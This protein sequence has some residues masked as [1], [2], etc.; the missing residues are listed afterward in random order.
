[1][2]AELELLRADHEAERAR[3][4]SERGELAAQREQQQPPPPSE[5][6]EAAQSW[7]AEKA[8]MTERLATAEKR[9][10][11]TMSRFLAMQGALPT[12][13]DGGASSVA[14]GDAPWQPRWRRRRERPTER[15]R[16]RLLELHDASSGRPRRGAELQ[17]PPALA[18]R[19]LRA[20][21]L[22]L[23]RSCGAMS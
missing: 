4:E 22:A 16:R 23:A 9:A 21:S 19:A 10:I 1:M 8:M 13:L 2:Q 17:P 14:A 7:M 18:A 6:E 20:A 5:Q 3:W 15:A 11:D 12:E